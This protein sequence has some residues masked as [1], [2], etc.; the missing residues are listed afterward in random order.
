M[1]IELVAAMSD[2]GVIGRRGA[3]PWRV[4]GEQ[5]HFREIT[6]GGT[7][8]MGSKT[9]R[10]IGR[11]L[12]GR[13]TIVLS[14]SGFTAE[15]CMSAASLGEAIAKARCSGVP[16]YIAGGGEIYRQALPL[17]DGIHLT[18]VHTTV[19]GDVTFPEVPLDEFRPVREKHYESDINYTYRYYERRHPRGEYR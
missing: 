6:L 17:A 4:R 19:V 18:Q 8:V 15:G 10:S 12:P 14:R 13:N 11:P 3:I 1:R 16:M 2:N 5:K 7:L 9:F